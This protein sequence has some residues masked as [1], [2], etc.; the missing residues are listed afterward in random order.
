MRALAEAQFNAYEGRPYD[1]RIR[2]SGFTNRPPF[3]YIYTNRR[4]QQQH[5]AKKVSTTNLV[6]TKRSYDKG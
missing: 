1:G 3:Q 4:E 6:A 5:A 2:P